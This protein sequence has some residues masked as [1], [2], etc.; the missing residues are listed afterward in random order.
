[1]ASGSSVLGQVTESRLEHLPP[2]VYRVLRPEDRQQL[3]AIH[4]ECFPVKYEPSFYDRSVCGD[5]FSSA[6]FIDCSA[7]RSSACMD[8]PRPPHCAQPVSIAAAPP[9]LQNTLP[10]FE[11]RG[12]EREVVGVVLPHYDGAMSGMMGGR[13]RGGEVREGGREGGEGGEHSGVAKGATGELLETRRAAEEKGGLAPDTLVRDTRMPAGRGAPEALSRCEKAFLP[14]GTPGSTHSGGEPRSLERVGR[15]EGHGGKGRGGLGRDR[16][17]SPAPSLDREELAAVIISQIS[18]QDELED[19]VLLDTNSSHKVAYI[20]TL[21][22]FPQFRQH[23]L[24][25]PLRVD[26]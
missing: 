6:A 21:G 11:S 16:G 12:K 10:D 22:V 25:V 14:E 8:S 24:A 2:V 20:C 19:R 3:L 13:G 4:E 5:L 9:P 26:D 17:Q 1:M 18:K 7:N 23:R 15:E